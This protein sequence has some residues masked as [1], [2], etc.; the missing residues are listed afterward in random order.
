M[1]E[2][3]MHDQFPF[4]EYYHIVELLCDGA[5]SSVY[6]AVQKAT[7]QYVAI[8]LIKGNLLSEKQLQERFE[9][10]VRIC[11]E[12]NHPYIV[13][14]L[15]TGYTGDNMPFVVFE[16]I[17]GI[18]LKQFLQ[19]EGAINL[20]L[21][22][23]LMGQVLDALACAH[24]MSI[25][26]RDLK[27]ENI[28]ITQPGARPY[29]KVLDFGIGAFT[30]DSF[31]VDNAAGTPAYCAPE[32]LRGEPPSTRSDIYAW[33][34]L[35]TECI[36]GT[37]VFRGITTAAVYEGQLS[38]DPVPLPDFIAGHPLTALLQRV[39]EKKAVNR[40]GDA[41]LLLQELAA[42][43]FMDLPLVAPV[44]ALLR[45]SNTGTMDNMLAWN[46]DK[47]EKRLITVLSIKLDVLGCRGSHPEEELLEELQ[48]R[49]LS[50]CAAIA[51]RFGGF[52]KGMMADH[53]L[54]YFGYPQATDNDA[55]MACRTALEVLEDMQQYSIT[56]Y[57]QKKVMLETR[58]T[59][60]TGTII[61]RRN[62]VPEGITANT[63][64]KLLH[65][66][67]ADRILVTDTTAAL[68]GTFA[69]LE[70]NHG[71][72]DEECLPVQE[73]FYVL[74]ERRA[75]AFSQLYSAAANRS[76]H[77][78]TAALDTIIRHFEQV[79]AGRRK[80]ILVTGDAGIGKS[81]L[82]LEA[83]K[84]MTAVTLIERRCLPEHR[85]IALFPFIEIIR[86]YYGLYQH[87]GAW[88]VP[89]LER[90]LSVAG[91]DLT[92]T[93]PVMLS[94]F[95]FPFTDKYPALQ[96]G[97]ADQKK[98]LF[99]ALRKC[100]G[101][102]SR[103]KKY[104][105]LLEDLQWMDPSSRE[106]LAGMIAE[107]EEE[108]GMFLLSARTEFMPGWDATSFTRLQLGPLDICAVRR[109]IEEQLGY[110]KKIAPASL[111]YVMRHTDGVPFFIEELLQLLLAE[112][113]LVAVRDTY[114]LMDDG[115]QPGVPLTL[116]EL[117][118]AK[119]DQTGSARETAQLAATIGREFSSR[120]LMKVAMK[121]V[122]SVWNDLQMLTAADIIVPL[123]T[124]KGLWYVFRH[125]LFCEVA[126]DSQ[127]APVREQAHARIAEELIAVIDPD[128]QPDVLAVNTL[129]QHLY[130][131]G[132]VAAAI[133]WLLT[134]IQQLISTSANREC[135]PLCEQAL[136]WLRELPADHITELAIRQYLLS[137]LVIVDGYGAT[138]VGEQLDIMYRLYEQLP[139]QEQL[140]PGMFIYTSYYAM[141]GDWKMAAMVAQRL[142]Q[143]ALALQDIK[144]AIVSS[145]FLGLQLFND[146]RFTEAAA[147]L[148]KALALYDPAS[149]DVR[150]RDEPA[151]VVGAGSVR[152]DWDAAIAAMEIVFRHY[153]T[154]ESRVQDCLRFVNSSDGQQYIT[155]TYRLLSLAGAG[156]QAYAIARKYLALSQQMAEK[157]QMMVMQR[158][159]CL[160]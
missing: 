106:F 132:N 92:V 145:V 11:A 6:K 84:K 78:R 79:A 122:C 115:R 67:P 28:M 138:T 131:A 37:P 64:F 55:R 97:P 117:L 26:H 19:Q 59:M 151:T 114:H 105:L 49:Q 73:T 25:V 108:G 29:A 128:G 5:H 82:L 155:E 146:G 94:C 66:T 27:P 46:Y 107:K 111:H 77:G 88:V 14:L 15:D 30:G 47:R 65:Y 2:P 48:H 119:L 124:E 32:Q 23:E 158:V 100:M 76:M 156:K 8:K 57:E 103:K 61:S 43:D 110:G 9:R 147:V 45:P 86:Q 102:I 134:G 93:L 118:H 36:T 75:E 116:K 143:Q 50:A 17:A 85:H 40:A 31:P 68:I 144:Y 18:T 133:E 150:R 137:N 96:A 7:R 80:V 125:M 126:Y 58:Q 69:E 74:K 63:G 56:L 136:K 3:S 62:R 52:V 21:A 121:E 152:N 12:I 10:E 44:D 127:P 89:L 129:A 24:S 142:C 123:R 13:K 109:M 113:W 90:L 83:R 99:Q 112:G 153:V 53:L 140:L 51:T 91:C 71:M 70:K 42:M 39:L 1:E 34:L 130:G 41:H 159:H 104:V 148:E 16:Y 120:L 20:P 60:H 54:I 160:R 87:A 135:I 72:T 33:G 38:P 81:R 157:Q 22:V 141:R 139:A 154:A 149:Q 95:G 4:M 101:N 35:L 98:I